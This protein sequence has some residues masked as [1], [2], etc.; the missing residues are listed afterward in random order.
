LQ[1]I[2]SEVG[3]IHE[4]RDARGELDQLLLY[5][6]AFGLELL[7]L[8]GELPFLFRRQIELLGLA[9]QLFDLFALVDDR[10]DDVVAESALA[11][12]TLHGG[13][14]LGILQDAA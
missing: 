14:R 6:L 9:L 2:L 5:E 4:C 10:L 3:Q 13:H 12:D 7:L 1:R 8:I 11:L